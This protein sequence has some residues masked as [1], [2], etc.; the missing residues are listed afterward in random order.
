MKAG[1]KLWRVSDRRNGSQLEVTVVSVGRKW[2]QLD[3]G[4]RCLIE[5]GAVDGGQYSSP[6]TCWK[7]RGEYE[8]ARVLG[9]AW[10][11]FRDKLYGLQKPPEGVTI[12]TITQVCNLLGL[13]PW[14]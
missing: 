12:E 5:D 11:S 9:G 7:S 3:N 14:T 8:S 4:E 2:A 6:A 1:D 13:K 10:S